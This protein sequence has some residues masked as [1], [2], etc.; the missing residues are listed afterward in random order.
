MARAA[1]PAR[2]PDAGAAAEDAEAARS[3]PAHSHPGGD[4]GLGQDEGSG[5]FR[6]QG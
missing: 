2:G 6:F 1:A 5:V 4:F 3:R